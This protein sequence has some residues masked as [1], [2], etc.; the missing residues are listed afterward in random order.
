MVPI[1]KYTEPMLSAPLFQWMPKEGLENFEGCFDLE[2]EEILRSE[3]RATK[4]RIGYLLSGSALLERADGFP[5]AITEGYLFGISLSPKEGI[6][7]E[8]EDALLT[9]FS[10]CVILWIDYEKARF[11]CYGGCWF[12]A[13]LLQEIPKY[14]E[15][16]EQGNS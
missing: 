7:F 1:K 15:R 14:L 11:V 3:T 6:S 13:R 12:H 2:A 16:Q 8:K 5:K 10:N 9:A 4:G